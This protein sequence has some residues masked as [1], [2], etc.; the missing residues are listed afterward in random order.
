MRLAY[1]AFYSLQAYDSAPAA[2]GCQASYHGD[3]FNCYNHKSLMC[4][5]FRQ[6]RSQKQLEERFQAEAEA[7]VEVVPRYNIAP[8]Q[9]VVTVRQERGKALRRL[10]AMRWGLIPSWAKDMSYGN[11][12]V[13]ARSET[14]TTKLSFSD[15]V[16][17][18]RCLIPADG[19][20]E[21][22]KSGKVRQPYLFEV[23]EG[24][25]FAF[26]GLWDEWKNPEGKIIESCTI[27]TTT[28]N[29][30]LTDIHDRMPV[31]TTP[32]KYALWLNPEVEDFAAVRE[33]LK[34]Y[35]PSLMRCY[36]V[37]TKV[38]HVQN[39]NADC[40]APITLELTEQARLF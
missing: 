40:A 4:G 36:P 11:Q 8:T 3:E 29:T 17:Y 2:K 14:V 32:D 23:G 25:L 39:E 31:I 19:F 37:S 13:N 10:S 20:Y 35:D 26:A 24:E 7:E 30:L 34:P 9:P 21:W 33:I 22:K 18:R 5:R 16:R 15:S 38:N 6:T 1:F 28:P 27:L 12:T